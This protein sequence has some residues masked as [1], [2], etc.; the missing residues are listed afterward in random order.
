MGDRLTYRPSFQ[1]HQPPQLPIPGSLGPY[2]PGMS[3]V[4]S[5]GRL[6]STAQLH[7]GPSPNQSQYSQYSSA[8]VSP[9]PSRDQAMSS[10]PSSVQHITVAQVSG[11]AQKRAY[12]QR[13]KDPS[14]DACRERKVK[15]DATDTASCSECHSRNVK[16]QFTKETNR[17]MSSMKQ[18]QDLEKQLAQA[19][20]TI[21]SL[22][23]KV[24]SNDTNHTTPLIPEINSAPQRRP[25]PPLAPSAVSARAHIRN[26]SRGVFK[27]PPPYRQ[28]GRQSHFLPP[29]PQLPDRQWAEHI[30]SSYYTTI[31]SYIPIL[32][33]PSFVE[34][35]ER[36]YEK[37][38]LSGEPP[39]WG[40]LLFAVFACGLQYTFDPKIR[41]MY[42]DNGRKLIEQSR[43]LTDLFN[44]EFTIDHARAAL[45][46]SIFLMEI[47]CKS[48]SW[49]WLG[50]TVRIAQDIGLHR[51]SGPWGVVENEVRRRVWWGIYVWD[52]LLSVELG[53]VLLIDD[54]DCDINLP[55]PVDDHF[56]TESGVMMPPGQAPPSSNFLLTT[57]H[58]VRLI[59]P[60][61]QSLSAAIISPATLQMFD[62]YF[63]SCMVAFPPHCQ[64][65]HT[66]PLDPRYLHP[67]CHL[68]NSRLVLHRHNLSTSCT[69]EVRSLAMEAC[70]QAAKD[71]VA[72]LQ[73][74]MQWKATDGSQSSASWQTGLVTNATAMLCTHIWRCTLF[75]LYRGHFVEAAT[76]IQASTTIGDARAV[77]LACGRY[78]YGFLSLFHERLNK[79]ESIEDEGVLAIVSGDVQGSSESSW[80]W[81]GSETGTAL[82]NAS[83]EQE[84]GTD[85]KGPIVNGDSFS[86][87]SLSPEEARD[88]GGWPNIKWM[89]QGLVDRKERGNMMVRTN[90]HGGSTIGGS[91][92]PSNMPTPSPT[93]ALGGASRIS[94]PNII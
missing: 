1:Q 44:D 36:V 7:Q 9:G 91:N 37:G 29:L 72:L 6:T 34:V 19:K 68:Q 25:L 3:N 80:I 28:V 10:P 60:L 65:N 32:H 54:A 38:D 75:L 8:S 90:S 42:P 50:L 81:A 89:A 78:L 79:G 93:P 70:V 26:Y 23:S 40:S 12:R 18:V 45:L 20:A 30:L 87:P 69:S 88:W 52:R 24:D 2:D 31:H 71:T 46:T 27:P 11:T 57:I 56:I 92:G 14:C 84:I 51:E 83:T 66:S 35:Y 76:C 53:R 17:R 85:G 13:R 15:C 74:V 62:S 41:G 4:S 58:V 49:T 33:W 77:N 39:S 21:T 22:R 61:L 73:R 5:T 43:M 67:M 47:N 86:S 59:G 16:C 82:K 48:A 63:N 64:I 94:I 55:C